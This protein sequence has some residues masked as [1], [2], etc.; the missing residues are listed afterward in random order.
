MNMNFQCFL[1]FTTAE[2]RIKTDPVE[3]ALVSLLQ[4][5]SEDDE[6][7]GFFMSLYTT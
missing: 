4:T 7:N 2:K 1:K 5:D 6:D 3:H